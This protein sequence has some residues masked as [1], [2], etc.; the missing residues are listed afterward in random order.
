MTKGPLFTF[1]RS[2]ERSF[3]IFKELRD[4]FVPFIRIEQFKGYL[5]SLIV[6]GTKGSQGTQ[7]S[8]CA[9]SKE[10]RGDCVC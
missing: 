1:E 10:Q 5:G 3:F 9:L 8:L 6:K 7:A 2:G 4:A